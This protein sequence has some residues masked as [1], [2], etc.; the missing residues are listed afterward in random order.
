MRK[1]RRRRSADIYSEWGRRWIGVIRRD[2]YHFGQREPISNAAV[3][4]GADSETRPV[5]RRAW[6]MTRPS[7]AR[8][9]PA[10]ARHL[11]SPPRAPKFVG[12]RLA[13]RLFSSHRWPRT[14]DALQLKRFVGRTRLFIKYPP[15]P[16]PSDC[17]APH[18]HLIEHRSKM[19]GQ[20]RHDTFAGIDSYTAN[21]RTRTPSTP[22]IIT[23]SRQAQ[24]QHK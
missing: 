2:K 22:H 4:P 3:P 20:P 18:V 23:C 7:A 10:H 6:H 14:A 8:R 17:G 9:G 5:P 24:R 12:A 16:T 15:M 11:P 19:W 1:R 13:R 21:H